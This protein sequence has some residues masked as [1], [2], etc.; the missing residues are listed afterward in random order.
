VCSGP[1]RLG[2][3]GLG[4]WG[5]NFVRTIDALDGVSLAAVASRNPD[6]KALLAPSCAVMTEWRELLT[7]PKLDGIVVATPPE[8]HAEILIAAVEAGLPVLIEKP[9]AASRTA[10][11]AIEAALRQRA[12]IVVVDHTHLFAPGFRMLRHE[13]AGMGRLRRICASAGNHGPYRADVSVLWDWAPHDIAMALTLAPGPARARTARCVE[14]QLFGGVA[15][16]RLTLEVELAGA[17]PA[18]IQVSTLND[19]H[20]WFAAVF[21]AGTLVYR[22]GNASKL[23]RLPPNA[24]IQSTVGQPIWVADEM[25]L[26]RAVLDFMRAIRTNDTDRTSLELGLAVTELIADL[27]DMLHT[28]VEGLS[29]AP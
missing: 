29:A 23:V 6:A 8:S 25:P 28:D 3:V 10:G 1:L 18:Y 20:R 19:R 15:A 2:I 13:A 12:A 26:T 5:R 14:R 4:R 16:E 7:I 9:L 24:E 17:V 21:E 22:D 27:D 11:H